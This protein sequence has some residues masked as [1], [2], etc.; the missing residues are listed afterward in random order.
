[1]IGSMYRADGA[2]DTSQGEPLGDALG[3]LANHLRPEM[4]EH[5]GWE[6]A[7]QLGKFA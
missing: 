7:E 4:A 6:M 5:A 3:L 2:K 1:M